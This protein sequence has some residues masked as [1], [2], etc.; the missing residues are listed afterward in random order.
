MSHN[1]HLHDV[2]VHHVSHGISFNLVLQE[3]SYPWLTLC[4]FLFLLILLLLFLDEYVD[5]YENHTFSG[6]ISSL[7]ELEGEHCVSVSPNET[8]R[9]I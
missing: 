9:S 3:S 8:R 1:T 5:G 7:V 6:T 4:V 2:N